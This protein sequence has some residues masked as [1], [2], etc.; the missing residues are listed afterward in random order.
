M[1][2]CRTI[3]AFSINGP[4]SV[5]A[6]HL[7]RRTA[8]GSATRPSGVSTRG[9]RSRPHLD[10]CPTQRPGH[11]DLAP[12]RGP[13]SPSRRPR[14]QRG[15][16][17]PHGNTGLGRRPWRPPVTGRACAFPSAYRPASARTPQAPYTPDAR[18]GTCPTCL[19]SIWSWV[20]YC[21]T[22]ETA[23]PV[24]ARRSRPR[25]RPDMRL[26]RGV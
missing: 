18:G 5:R 19:G 17:K 24:A 3:P 10:R 9:R 6:P 25:R 15:A 16:Q 4:S 8:T 26:A 12:T 21:V 11:R 7:G 2:A 13:G 23:A 20:K 14:P 1:S 22:T